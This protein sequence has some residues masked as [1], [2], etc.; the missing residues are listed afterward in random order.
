MFNDA[1]WRRCVR[2]GH[3]PGGEPSRGHGISEQF[4]RY[5][6]RRLPETA[7]GVCSHC[8]GMIER[9]AGFS[10]YSGIIL[11]SRLLETERTAAR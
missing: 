10:R 9:S 8:A 5:L 6:G 3:T 1:F 11:G 2:I 7:L 4:Y